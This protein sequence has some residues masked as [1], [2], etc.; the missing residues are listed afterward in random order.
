M[1]EITKKAIRFTDLSDNTRHEELLDGLYLADTFLVNLG[2]AEAPEYKLKY[3]IRFYPTAIY[4]VSKEDY[5]WCVDYL[6]K[7][8]Q[9][10][11]RGW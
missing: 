6:N 7:E 10:S 2:L 1:E 3:R 5:D 9:W 8:S 4:E 11:V